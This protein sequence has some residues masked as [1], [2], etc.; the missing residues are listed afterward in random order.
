[1]LEAL[2]FV[3]GVATSVVVAYVKESYQNDPFRIVLEVCLVFFT[4]RYL[5]GGSRPTVK[6]TEREK[7]QLIDDWTPTPVTQLFGKSDAADEGAEQERLEQERREQEDP[8]DLDLRRTHFVKHPKDLST[9]LCD[10]VKKYGVGSCGPPGFYGTLDLHVQ[11][12]AQLARFF[13]TES[14]VLY[15]QAFSAVASTI[16]AFVKKGD[17]VVADSACHYAIQVGLRI[18]RATVYHYRHNDL[19][20]LERVLASIED[21]IRERRLTLPRKYVVAEALY[22]E[23]GQQLDL[24]RLVQL[25]WQHK[26]RIILDETTSLGLTTGQGGLCLRQHVDPND[27]DIVVGSLSHGVGSGGGFA[28][29]SVHVGD[30]QRL[31]SQAYCFSVSTPAMLSKY[32]MLTLPRMDQGVADNARLARIF[33]QHLVIPSSWAQ[34]S[35]A[36]SPVICL[37]APSPQQAA[38]VV[39][40]LRRDYRIG[41]QLSDFFDGHVRFDPNRAGVRAR[42]ADAVRV[43]VHSGLSDAEAALAAQALSKCMQAAI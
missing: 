13:G 18:S 37:K 41:A 21:M 42:A 4:L 15:S 7:E 39:E 10:I 23:T 24:P 1:M 8:V 12:E 35:A 29:G 3:Y 20:D 26:C 34:L 19:D 27:V 9:Q 32:A 14:A 33:H 43:A 11:L 38:R 30:H 2:K 36:D 5:F 31:N 28:C 17:I 25:K 16:P 22:Q 6:L 40:S